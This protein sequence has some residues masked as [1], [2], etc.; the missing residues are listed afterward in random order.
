MEARACISAGLTTAGSGGQL[1]NELGL[2]DKP[3]M[4]WQKCYAAHLFG[5]EEIDA[6]WG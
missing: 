6:I 4:N 1:Q 5:Y 2:M 3:H